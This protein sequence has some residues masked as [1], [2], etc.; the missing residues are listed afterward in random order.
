MLSG[1]PP[2]VMGPLR[3]PAQYDARMIR[4]VTVTTGARLH[5]GPLAVGAARGRSFGGVG[6][7][8]DAP[9]WEVMIERSERDEVFAEAEAGRIARIRDRFRRN[10]T[11]AVPPC[12]VTPTQRMP[13]HSG[14][15]SGT[16]LALAIAKGLSLL[17][18]EADRNVM[19]LARRT[20]R[21]QRSAIGTHGFAEG[22]FLVDAGR[23]DSSELGELACRAAMPSDWR[24]L[25]VTPP[26]RSGI[27]G[28]AER[29]AFE[30]LE[31]MPPATTD[32]LC[33]IVVMDWLPAVQSGNFDA[34]CAALNEFGQRVGE[35][36]RTV[37]GGVF[38][39]EQMV[40]LA[41]RLH[42]AGF[43]G[44]A[45]SS[46]GPTIAVCCEDENAATQ[47][48]A[49]LESNPDC[50]ECIVRVARPLNDAAHVN[51]E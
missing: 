24:F 51:V 16:Q 5:F 11:A 12:R 39:D 38:S 30:A 46:W 27:S 28:S 49:E 34:F 10:S 44:V 42:Q 35:Y 48:R 32:A 45:Q 4:R 21:G 8:I 43:R 15:G 7:M 14:L 13:A 9:G 19:E 40:R 36:F 31:P 1:S 17:V 22:G 26:K 25:L 37:Q 6:L 41:A 50:R 47:L 33:R 2:A 18:G 23:P 20:E 3:Q 29:R